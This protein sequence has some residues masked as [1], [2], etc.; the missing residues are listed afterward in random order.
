MIIQWSQHAKRPNA[1]Q[2]VVASRNVIKGQYTAPLVVESAAQTRFRG[3]IV[4]VN[5]MGLR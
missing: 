4:N 1:P 2:H 3:F 5:R